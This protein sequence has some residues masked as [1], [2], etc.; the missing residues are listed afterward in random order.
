MKI[1]RHGGG[2][3]RSHVHVQ[4]L[5]RSRERVERPGCQLSRD[6]GSTCVS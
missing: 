6:A 4:L 1:Q 2:G 5:R 3:G